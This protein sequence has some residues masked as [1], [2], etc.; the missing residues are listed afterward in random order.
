MSNILFHNKYHLT[1]HHTVSTYGYPDSGTDPLGA[2]DQEFLGTFYNVFENYTNGALVST[3]SVEW[4]STFTTLC[5]ASA[6]LG[7]NNYTTTYRTVTALSGGWSDGYSFYT[8]YL[9]GSARY[10]E[11]YTFTEA[12]SSHW[13][14]ISGTLRLNSAQENTQA[15]TF[16]GVYNSV[17]S[18]TAAFYFDFLSPNFNNINFAPGTVSTFTRSSSA[19]FISNNG[20]LSAV[21]PN[22][23]RQEY[24]YNA[25]TSAWDCQGLLIEPRG[26]NLLQYSEDFNDNTWIADPGITVTPDVVASPAITLSADRISVGGNGGLY[27]TVSVLPITTYTMSVYVKLNTLLAEDYKFA[28]YDATNSIY[29]AQDVAP[30]NTP[31]KKNWTRIAYTFTTPAGCNSI[32]LYP[33]A[34][35]SVIL[36]GTNFYLWGAQLERSDVVTSY[37]QTLNI[38]Q[39]REQEYA[40][41]QGDFFNNS[42]GTFFTETKFTGTTATSGAFTI[43]RLFNPTRTNTINI[44]LNKN[45]QGQSFGE[46]NNSSSL[47]FNLLSPFTYNAAIPKKIALG[48]IRNNIILADSGQIVATDTSSLVPTTL[49]SCY[50]GLS[51][52]ASDGN[53]FCGYI[54][55][56][57]YYR[58]KVNN[59]T[60]RY[61]T[62][63]AHDF[64]SINEINTVSWDLSSQ[65]VCFV[66]LTGDMFC[67]NRSTLLKRKGGNYTLVLKQDRDGR[68]QVVFDT[69][70]ILTTPLSGTNS[71]SLSSYSVTVIPFITDGTKLYG[72]PTYYYY[73]LAGAITY[74]EGDGILITPNPVG[75]LAGETLIPVVGLTIA[76]AGGAPYTQGAGI[77]IIEV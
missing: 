73:G 11:V 41:L 28:I 16:A 34:N 38:F 52:D 70:F 5:G 76:G 67:E 42:E 48:Y 6:A 62:L 2:K 45:K 12:N 59:N 13:P 20:N 24:T 44:R 63:S 17:N 54:R 66:A 50:I 43:L 27:Q 32:N 64:Q 21:G 56:I 4:N 71:V 61:L 65:Q 55:R 8:T 14:F 37:I 9:A 58:Q 69:D 3:N 75:M 74:F 53:S 36:G 49:S 10:R 19:T 35:T 22:I 30:L 1:N 31:N 57:G 39:T 68:R 7:F 23:P 25:I 26:T 72:K 47:T 33:Y 46:V 51:A 29:I 60:L 40:T 15:K 77:T 18:V